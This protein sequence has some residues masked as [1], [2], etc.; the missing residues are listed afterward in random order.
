MFLNCINLVL[1]GKKYRFQCIT[2]NGTSLLDGL[3]HPQNEYIFAG[4]LEKQPFKNLLKKIV[5]LRKRNRDAFFNITVCICGQILWYFNACYGVRFLVY[6]QVAISHFRPRQ[7]GRDTLDHSIFLN[8]YFC[9]IPPWKLL[10]CCE[11]VR[12]IPG[13]HPK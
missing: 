7:C 3:Q 13:K 9:G 12:K 1:S 6:L 11:N 5:V 2:N 4:V 8:N 10:L